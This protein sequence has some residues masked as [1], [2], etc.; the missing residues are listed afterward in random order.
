MKAPFFIAVTLLASALPRAGSALVA[1]PARIDVYVAPYYNSH[2]PAIE[3]GK[4]SA[5]LASKN[6]KKFVATIQSMKRHW[7]ELAFS[8]M[9][10]AAIR[11]Y[12]AGYRNEAVYWFYSAQYRGR[13]FALL[14]DRNKIGSIGSPGFELFH[15]QDAFLELVGPYINGYAFGDPD[16]LAKTIRRVQSENRS[17]AG[18]RA[19]YPGVAFT[20]V[21]AWK[22]QN[23]QLNQGMDKLVAMLGNQ[24]DQIKRQRVQNGIEAQFSRLPS[25]PLPG[26]I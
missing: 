3:V 5:G 22:A 24:K 14:V 13:Q 15:A 25:K 26:G 6:D 20:D 2:G 17:V 11:L 8:E 21:A 10:V 19:I 7:K 4:A 1:D 12:D 9:Y 16:S 18:L 23:E